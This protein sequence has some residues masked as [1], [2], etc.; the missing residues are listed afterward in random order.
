MKPKSNGIY[1]LLLAFVIVAVL[2]LPQLIGTTMVIDEE[3]GIDESGCP[4]T[5]MTLADLEAPGTIFGSPMFPEYEMAIEERFPEGEI[6]TYSSMPNMY[7]GLEAG[8][9]EDRKSV[10]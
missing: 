4:A 9:V 1:E 6:R 2:L 7:A 3:A 8:E 5:E 10:V